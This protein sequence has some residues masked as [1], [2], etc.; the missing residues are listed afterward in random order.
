MQLA[1]WLII[2]GV[3]FIIVGLLLT[4]TDIKVWFSR[5]ISLAGYLGKLPGDIHIKGAHYSFYFPITTMILLS[6]VANLLL[7]VIRM[8]FP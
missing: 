5:L 7:K 3:L 2:A 4:F 1:K 6:V 8:L